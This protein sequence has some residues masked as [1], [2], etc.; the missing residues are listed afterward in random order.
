MKK[1]NKLHVITDCSTEVC[2]PPIS[3]NSFDFLPMH[4]RE[5]DKKADNFS[6][7]YSN[8]RKRL[9]CFSVNCHEMYKHAC[10]VN[11]SIASTL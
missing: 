1:I 2:P 5:R 8:Y 10:V 11:A 6:V 4:I 7:I 9:N 3:L